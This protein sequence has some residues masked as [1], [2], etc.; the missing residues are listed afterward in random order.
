[1]VELRD[2][3]PSPLVLKYYAYK[4]TVTFG[5]FWPIFTLYLLHQDL[6]YAQIGVLGSISAALTVV[7]E[8]PTGYVADRIGRRNSLA[9]SS[10]LLTISVLGFVVAETFLA[11]AFLYFVWALGLGFQSG[12]GD[13]W[14]YDTLKE[15][16]R[17]DEFTRIRGRGGSVG[18]VFSAGSML[19]SGVLYS[20]DPRL[21]FLVGGLLLA[22]SLPVVLSIPRNAREDVEDDDLGVLETASAIRETLMAPRLRSVIL[23]LAVFFAAIQSADTFIQ[24]IAVRTLELPEAGLGPMYA[25][26]SLVAAVGSYY[27][28][29]IQTALTTRWAFVLVPAVAAVFFVLPAVVP[30]VAFPMF[31]VM[32]ATNEVMRPIASGYLNDH[33]ES[34]NRATLLSGAAMVYALVRLPL[35]PLTGAVADVTSPIV[36]VAALGVLMAVCSV[37]LYGMNPFAES[38]PNVVAEGSDG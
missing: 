25:A 23:Y 38:S 9:I 21:P 31:F 2:S 4:A 11:F 35:K 17:E 5:F 7:G 36:T 34:L 6:T 14:L 18:Q 16:L 22:A 12:T 26:F 19:A 27:A 10:V 29:E 24:P 1:M 37:V 3:L 32:K 33:V 13:A 8:V 20:V 30:L 28:D 15:Q